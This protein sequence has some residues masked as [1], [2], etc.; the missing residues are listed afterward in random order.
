M[1]DDGTQWIWPELTFK[2][3]PLMTM[4]AYMIENGEYMGDE[5]LYAQIDPEKPDMVVIH[6]IIGD[7]GVVIE[8][9]PQ[10]AMAVA[11]QISDIAVEVARGMSKEINK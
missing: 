4:K 9:E 6:Y 7:R 8:M 1:S 2:V 10:R 11:R 3:E 5:E